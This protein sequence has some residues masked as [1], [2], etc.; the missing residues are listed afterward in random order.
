MANLVFIINQADKYK[1]LCR[2]PDR[3]MVE[4]LYHSLWHALKHSFITKDFNKNGL[5]IS[6]ALK[7]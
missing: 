1:S 7:Q 6:I 2:V 4:I 3:G 5:N